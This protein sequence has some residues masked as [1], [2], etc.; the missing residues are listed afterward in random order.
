MVPGCE[1]DGHTEKGH[2]EA[3]KK[4]SDRLV[5]YVLPLPAAVTS[6][7]VARLLALASDFPSP[8]VLEYVGR[9]LDWGFDLCFRGEVSDLRDT[10]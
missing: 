5:R 4:S 3:K 9:G 6:Y 7:R 1:E 8:G 10:T 2:D